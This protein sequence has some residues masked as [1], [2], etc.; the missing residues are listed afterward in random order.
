[1]TDRELTELEEKWLDVLF[2]RNP[3]GLGS[4]FFT[5]EELMALNGLV[6]KGLAERHE[7]Q[8]YPLFCITDAGRAAIKKLI[9]Q[10]R[11]I[12]CVICATFETRTTPVEAFF[13]GLMCCVSKTEK[14]HVTPQNVWDEVVRTL[15]PEHREAYEAPGK[16]RVEFVAKKPEP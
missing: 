10:W 4:A 15:C 1:M 2:R 6:T 12:G 11:A 5:E 9:S 16:D 3:R 14:H 8:C 7:L 13:I